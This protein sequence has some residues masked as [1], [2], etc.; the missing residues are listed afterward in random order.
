MCDDCSN[1]V[2]VSVMGFLF[3][4]Y[5]NFF[6]LKVCILNYNLVL[7]NQLNINT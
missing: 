4:K 7:L 6:K 5:F 2:A 3:L 1:P